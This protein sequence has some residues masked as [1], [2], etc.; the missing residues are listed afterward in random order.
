MANILWKSMHY[1]RIG[2]LMSLLG[3]IFIPILITIVDTNRLSLVKWFVI[4]LIIF[5]LFR[6]FTNA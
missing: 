3:I 4:S 6:S 2:A 5:I 1:N